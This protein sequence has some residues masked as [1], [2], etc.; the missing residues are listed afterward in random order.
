M[1]GSENKVVRKC[2]V[3]EICMETIEGICCRALAGDRMACPIYRTFLD[4]AGK[5][6]ART[7]PQFDLQFKQDDSRM[8]FIKDTMDTKE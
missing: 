4:D 7:K 1:R 3:K 2:T 8:T 6:Q 5:Q